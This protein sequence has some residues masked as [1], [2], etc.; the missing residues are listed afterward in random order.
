[1]SSAVHAL[2]YAVAGALVVLAVSTIGQWLR[3]R[4]SPRGWSAAGV[5]LLAFVAVLG[6]AQELSGGRH[7][8]LP[9]LIVVAFLGSG[10]CLLS[11]RHCV[12]PVLRRTRRI[13]LLAAVGAGTFALAAGLPLG[14]GPARS[15][16]QLAA[17]VLLVA[18]WTAF[19][20]EPVV[21]FWRMASQHPP[22]QRARL[23]TVGTAYAGVI[24]IL[25][26]A[27][28]AQFRR[29]SIGSLALQLLALLV[30]PLLLVGFSPPGPIRRAWRRRE[31][32]AL[33]AATGDLVTARHDRVGL[34]GTALEWAVRLVGADAGFI[35]EG[36][37]S[38]LA[39]R[40]MQAEEIHRVLSG[41]GSTRTARM[42]RLPGERRRYAIAHPIPSDQAEE[43]ALL[44]VVSG[45][46][47]PIFGSEEVARLGEYAALVAVALD[48]VRMYE[49]LR[50]E[51]E[52]HQ[53][54]VQ[55][56][57]DLGVG[58]VVVQG[59]EVVYANE[60]LSRINGYTLGELRGLPSFL[61]V[62]VPEDRE[63]IADQMRR[64]LRG[65]P[66]PD[67][68]ET[69]ILHMDGGHVEVEVTA[70]RIGVG[71]RAQIVALVR[72]ITDRKRVEV[73]LRESEEAFRLAYEQEHDVAERLRALD[74]MK[75]AFLTAVSHE[76]RTP[77]T[78]VLGFALTLQHQEAGLDAHERSLLVDRLIANARK[79][80]RLLSDL[81]D[82]DRLSRGVLELSVRP[83]D[84][85]ALALRV[86]EECDAGLRRVSVDVG[87]IVMPMDGAKVERILENLLVN[88]A[89]HTPQGT[90]VWIRAHTRDDGIELTVDDEG[91]GIPDDEKRGVF[92]PFRRGSGTQEHSP[93]TGAGLA[94][95]ARFAELHGG[96][97]WVQDRPGGGSSFR[98]FLPGTPAKGGTIATVR[99]QGEQPDAAR[100]RPPTALIEPREGLA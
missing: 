53:S 11:F 24:A 39:V 31:E 83:T 30:V 62:I 33:R 91:P 16:V 93:G 13:A 50:Q 96:R 90:R 82:L 78:A 23:R 38:L 25:W 48:R 63:A 8:I 98:V 86:V 59:S 79:L 80:A 88:A 89:R 40:G 4:S 71:E 60:A 75:S 97:V 94:I 64:R 26:V 2:A 55:A 36:D 46:A 14:P 7:R 54:L 9:D 74:E 99:S 35:V 29:G 3:D 85:R 18:V 66:V 1:M 12:F 5:G 17:A 52:R 56:A 70:K 6:R 61:D 41:V 77:L 27:V 69:A 57:G 81:L 72:D 68:Y 22:V 84:L 42:V 20:G 19:V 87:P 51:K 47:T 92:E 28:A 65:E 58:I 100:R 95:V 15:P 45:P 10:Y 76:L 34:A 21:R 67:H 73:T 43:A 49:A 32:A 44:V 37:R